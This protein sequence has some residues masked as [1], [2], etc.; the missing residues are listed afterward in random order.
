MKIPIFEQE[1]S[2]SFYR[3]DD[4]F[5]VYTSDSTMITKLD[6]LVRDGSAWSLEKVWTQQGDIVGKTYSAPKKCI[7]Y[8]ANPRICNFTEEQKR[9]NAERL[10][11]WRFNSQ[12]ND[13]ALNDIMEAMLDDSEDTETEE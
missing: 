10:K 12:N 13:D 6:K 1:T 7:M 8:L 2:I 11:A 4:R 5:E 9:E 3:T